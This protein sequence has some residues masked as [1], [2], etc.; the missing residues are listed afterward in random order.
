MINPNTFQPGY[1]HKGTILWL[2][3]LFNGLL[4]LLILVGLQTLTLHQK[5]NHKQIQSHDQFYQLESVMYQLVKQP[6]PSSCQVTIDSP[7]QSVELLRR[8]HGCLIQEAKLTY[9][10]VLSDLGI[11]PCL[12][13][14]V[15]QQVVDSQQMLCTVVSLDNPRQILQTRWAWPTQ[16]N[17]RCQGPQALILKTGLMSWRE[18]TV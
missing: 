16:L 4:T 14:K 5:N 8:Q 13:I 2:V 3:L 12:K 10:Y 11:H 15:D 1:A 9:R 18:L 17:T 7:N 6:H